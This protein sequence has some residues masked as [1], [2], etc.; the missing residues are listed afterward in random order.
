INL[1]VDLGGAFVSSS[2]YGQ[3]YSAMEALLKKLAKDQA[4]VAVEDQIKSEEK[5]LKH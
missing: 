1:F 2:A 3:Q 5:V 4:L